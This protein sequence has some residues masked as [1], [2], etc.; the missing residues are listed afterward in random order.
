[1]PCLLAPA[2]VPASHE[3]GFIFALYRAGL[4]G[5]VRVDSD[6]VETLFL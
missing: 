3:A 4:R 2:R 5:I 6:I 1:M